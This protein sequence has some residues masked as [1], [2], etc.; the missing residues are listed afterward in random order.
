MKK[1]II[2][3]CGLLM[4]SNSVIYANQRYDDVKKEVID[5]YTND[6]MFQM[7]LEEDETK[8]MKFIEIV[9]ENRIN[10]D[11]TKAGNYSNAYSYVNTYKQETSYTC[12][13]ASA[14]QILMSIGKAPHSSF[15]SNENT[16]AEEMGTNS[17][18]GTLVYKLT[19]GINKYLTTGKY[20]YVS[21][22]SLSESV[23]MDKIATS[24]F[25]NRPPILHAKTAGLDYYDGLNIG[26]YI[27]VEV[28]NRNTNIVRVDD[29]NNKSK[30]NG[31][32]NVT[33]GE[34]KEALP[35]GRYL[36]YY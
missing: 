30:Y 27:T 7:Q 17:N 22:G 5:E 15:S 21:A 28:A 26:H 12:G 8:A 24:L 6:E 18:D 2:I 31:Q 3:I 33:I 4:F 23:L 10:K 19:E 32:H 29:V 11:N 1:F 16:L 13:P 20:T 34:I 35:S 25:Y 9:V 36:I 14:S